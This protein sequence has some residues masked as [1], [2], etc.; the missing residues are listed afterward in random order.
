MIRVRASVGTEQVAAL[1]SRGV[2]A[3][4]LPTGL[5]RATVSSFQSAPMRSVT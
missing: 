1:R 4:P 2:F 3:P 5:K